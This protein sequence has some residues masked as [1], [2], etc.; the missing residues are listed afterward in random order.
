MFS[1]FE[2]ERSFLT[3]DAPVKN[4]IAQ[5]TNPY[6]LYIK[7]KNEEKLY[8]RQVYTFLSMI[9]DVGGLYDGLLILTGVFMGFYNA[10]FFKYEL[11]KSLFRFQKTP[12]IQGSRF[13]KI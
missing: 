6:S 8:K 11:V 5:T 2:V 12:S 3:A 4:P 1:D 10:T 7:L 9:G 13:K